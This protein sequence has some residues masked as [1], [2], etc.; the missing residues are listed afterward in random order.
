MAVPGYLIT[1]RLKATSQ[2]GPKQTSAILLLKSLHCLSRLRCSFSY[3]QPW[4]PRTVNSLC[5]IHTGLYPSPPRGSIGFQTRLRIT[6][7]SLL[8]VLL[9]SLKCAV[10]IQCIILDVA[11]LGMDTSTKAAKLCL[12]AMMQL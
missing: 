1:S 10:R 11:L 9:Y 4:F 8:Y 6:S 7:V 12:R 2:G 5:H 3:L